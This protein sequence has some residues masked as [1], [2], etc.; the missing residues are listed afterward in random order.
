MEFGYFTLSDNH[1]EG[2]T[3]DANTFVKD[4]TAEAALW[5]QDRHAF[6]LD[7]RA[8]LQFAQRELVAGNA[9]GLYRGSDQA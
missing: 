8:S 4:L 2:N 1:Y 5:R 7:R 9:A 3:R 6:G